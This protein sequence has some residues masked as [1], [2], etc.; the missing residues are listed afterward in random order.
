MTMELDVIKCAP[1]Y[2]MLDAVAHGMAWHDARYRYGMAAPRYP[3]PATMGAV[4][5][6]IG[7]HD[8]AR[9]WANPMIEPYMIVITCADERFDPVWTWDEREGVWPDDSPNSVNNWWRK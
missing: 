4:D 9:P 8:R 2:E 1:V 6:D 5:H 3:M 7:A